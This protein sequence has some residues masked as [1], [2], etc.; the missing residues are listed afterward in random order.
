MCNFRKILLDF[1]ALRSS[2]RGDSFT[3]GRVFLDVDCSRNS[4][5]II[6]NWRFVAPIHNL[7][8]NLNRSR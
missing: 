6:P 5:K 2:D 8:L 7:D 1:R 3:N 4:F